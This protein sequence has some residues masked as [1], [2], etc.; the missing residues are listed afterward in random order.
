MDNWQEASAA[1]LGRAIGE[2]VLDPRELTEWFIE[3]I[4]THPDSGMIYARTTPARARIEAEA[5]HARQQS[6]NR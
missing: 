3:A 4:G 2:G 6:G 5:A 1:D